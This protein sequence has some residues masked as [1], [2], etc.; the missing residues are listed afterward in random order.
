MAFWNLDCRRGFLG[1]WRYGH[2]RIE[3]NGRVGLFNGETPKAWMDAA[4][5]FHAAGEVIATARLYRWM[6]DRGRPPV[7]SLL[8][9]LSRN[10]TG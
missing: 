3:R 5:N 6:D 4:G 2:F 7:F 10:A 1:D 9:L 8:R